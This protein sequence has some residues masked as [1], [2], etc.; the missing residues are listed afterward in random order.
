[1]MR[2]GMTDTMNRGVMPFLHLEPV[3][4]VTPKKKL[5]YS[6]TSRLKRPVKFVH[7]SRRSLFHTDRVHG[8]RSRWRATGFTSFNSSLCLMHKRLGVIS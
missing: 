4:A 5:D 6:I 2:A 1:M 8:A 7:N 3:T